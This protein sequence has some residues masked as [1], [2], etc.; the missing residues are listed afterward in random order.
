M[1]DKAFARGVSREDVVE[2]AA[3]LGIEL[4]AHITFVILSMQERAAMLGLEGSPGA[5]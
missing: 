2:G 1:K 5:G 3:A 4:D